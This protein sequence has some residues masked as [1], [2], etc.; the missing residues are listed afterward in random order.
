VHS[1]IRTEPF[2]T[3]PQLGDAEAQAAAAVLR[4]NE[5][6]Q[7]VGP[8][9]ADFESAFA[10]FHDA[11]H[12]IAVNNGT[13][14]LQAVF[15]AIGLRPGDEVLV[16]AH[17]F[18]ATATPVAHLGA[19]PVFVDIDPAT[20]C[21]DPVDAARKITDRTRA[22]VPV[23]VN[24]HPAPLAELGALADANGI[25]LVEDAAQAHGARYDGRPVGT[26]G[27]A[28]CFSFWHDKIIT[29]GGEGGAVLTTD[30]EL[31][32]T[33]RRTRNHGEAPTPGERLRRHVVLGH[34]Y[35]LT[36]MQAAVGSV[37]LGKLDGYLAARRANAAWLSEALRD[38]PGIVPPGVD[39][40]CQP[41]PWKYVCR[42]AVEPERLD[43][44]TF[45]AAVQAEGIPAQRRYPIP[46]HKQPIFTDFATEALPVAEW[47]GETLFSL[48]VHPGVSA[49]D[50]RD[51]V[52]AM[53]K[54]LRLHGVVA[55]VDAL[56]AQS[57]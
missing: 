38:L 40:R 7:S 1:S 37:Q 39:P 56:T 55:T 12:C 11:P 19:T 32:E 50:L 9:V 25:A 17:T 46:L 28:A 29:T 47:C 57:A 44:T 53:A 31:A 26:F 33:V 3:W 13:S 16:P 30:D 34:N 18:V 15:T 36:S 24:G 8:Q 5:L 27:V 41:S 43:L 49:D 54:V 51:C 4:A 23:H 20:Y 22:L 14:A 2:P 52:D 35:R 45:L 6:I 10:E 42:L 21:M 48:P